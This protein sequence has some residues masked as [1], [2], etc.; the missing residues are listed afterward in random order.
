LVL[1]VV[2][3]SDRDEDPVACTPYFDISYHGV[4]QCH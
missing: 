3:D 2:G 4:G 1:L